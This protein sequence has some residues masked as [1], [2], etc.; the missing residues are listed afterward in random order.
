M[1]SELKASQDIL[2]LKFV[3]ESTGWY[4]DLPE[5]TGEKGDLQMVSGADTFLDFLS[6]NGDRV[7]MNASISGDYE[8]T[9]V[10]KKVRDRPIGGGAD[11]NLMEY[12]KVIYPEGGHP[13]W[14][15][16]VTKFVFG[17]QLPDTIYFK[18]LN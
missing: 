18:E 7:D 14:L 15:C 17:G 3:K 13:M 1:K 11:Y 10:L 6:D 16:D 2:N 8:Y 4:I 9:G 5:W 12:D